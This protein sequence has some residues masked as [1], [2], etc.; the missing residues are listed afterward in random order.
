M[1]VRRPV[2]HNAREADTIDQM[3]GIVTGMEGKR[4]RYR[5]LI[6]DTGR[7]SGMWGL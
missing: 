4:L 7:S 1:S 5:D 2:G 3:A 6:T